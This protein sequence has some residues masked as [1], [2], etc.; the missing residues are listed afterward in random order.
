MTHAELARGVGA[1]LILAPAAPP[2]VQANFDGGAD[3]WTN[4]DDS[5]TNAI[6][7]LSSGGV[8]GGY[9]HTSESGDSDVSYWVAPPQFLGNLS[10]AYGGHLSYQLRQGN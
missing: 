5:G 2:I 4:A 1:A 10:D 3:G 9:L 6:Q 7:W 8:S